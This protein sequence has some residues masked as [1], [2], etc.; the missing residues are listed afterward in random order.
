MRTFV[1]EEL[2][3]IFCSYSAVYVNTDSAI[4]PVC[5]SA[6]VFF[7]ETDTVASFVTVLLIVHKVF[8]VC[9]RLN[10]SVFIIVCLYL[11]LCMH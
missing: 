5:E 4:P 9:L 10:T 1:Q 2:F 6:R 7:V 3:K 11:S 8:S